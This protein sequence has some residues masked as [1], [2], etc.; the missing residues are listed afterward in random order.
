MT[1][2]ASHPLPSRLDAAPESLPFI[3]W[4]PWIDFRCAGLKGHNGVPAQRIETRRRHRPPNEVGS[5]T[6]PQRSSGQ[7]RH[8]SGYPSTRVSCR[9]SWLAALLFGSNSNFTE[10]TL[11]Q[12][13][14]LRC[15]FQ[16]AD[17]PAT[18]TGA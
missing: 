4:V 18:F 10:P 11:R 17:G 1:T 6:S 12:K 7:F 13:A 16:V 14:R 15:R 2:R 9:S 5:T 3:A 8:R